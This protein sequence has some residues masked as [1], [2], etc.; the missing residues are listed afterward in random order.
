[1]PMLRLK[2]FQI[3]STP[4]RGQGLRIGVTRHPPLRVP[5]ERWTRDGYFDIWFPVLA[6]SV[7]LLSRFKGRL[8]DRAVRKRFF[9]SYEREIMASAAGR[10]SVQL[11]AQIAARMPIS[12]GCYCEDESMCHRVRLLR[13]IR[14]SALAR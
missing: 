13:I 5:K 1:M 3:G 14:K 8:D 9:E 6:P 4:T 10:Q 2:T 12:V 11:L 7:K